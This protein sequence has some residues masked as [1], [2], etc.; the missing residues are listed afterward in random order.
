MRVELERCGSA[1]A[2]HHYHGLV[3]VRGLRKGTL[4]LSVEDLTILRNA[5]VLQ[6]NDSSLL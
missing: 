4:Q 3:T 1:E 2:D 6:F 5:A